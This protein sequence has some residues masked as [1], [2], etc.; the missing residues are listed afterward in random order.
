MADLR[1]TAVACLVCIIYHYKNYKVPLIAKERSEAGGRLQ[2]IRR[3]ELLNSYA[4]R[5]ESVRAVCTRLQ[6]VLLRLGKLLATLVLVFVVNG[7]RLYR[8]QQV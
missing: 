1:I 5:V 3:Y 6:L 8:Q 7:C 4:Q 2:S